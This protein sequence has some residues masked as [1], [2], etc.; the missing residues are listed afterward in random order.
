M[1]GSAGPGTATAPTP[2][3]LHPLPD[4]RVVELNLSKTPPPPTSSLRCAHHVRRVGEQLADER[5]LDWVEGRDGRRRREGGEAGVRRG[6]LCRPPE[7][8]E[9]LLLL[10]LLLRRGGSS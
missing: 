1:A 4:L 6:A 7:A 5:E 3:L 8:L 10:L 2:P 9:S